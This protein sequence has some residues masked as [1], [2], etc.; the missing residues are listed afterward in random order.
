MSNSVKDFDHTLIKHKYLV[1]STKSGVGKTSFSANL[2]VALSKKGGKVGFMDL[3]YDGT[4]ISRVLGLKGS[5][6]TDND[7][8]SMPQA[9]SDNLK[10]ISIE[11]IMK[12]ID[13]SLAFG[14]DFE[15][16]AI[17][18]CI[19]G[20]NW[21]EVDYLIVDSPPGSGD[22][23]LA[24]AQ[25]IKG[26]KVIFV[27][28]SQNE[29]LIEMEKLINFYSNLKIPIFGTIENMSGFLCSECDKTSGSTLQES[30]IMEIDYLGR[31]PL[32]PH[33]AKCTEA[34]ESYLEK[35]P[36]S[37]IAHGCEIIVKKII[38]DSRPLKRENK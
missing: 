15:M 4:N 34:G 1:T 28:T 21:G 36:D 19:T 13:P 32:D 31:I 16:H 18:Q 6:E 33:L 3:D 24:V 17:R 25:A 26:S 14:E 35:Y 10:V 23:S 29:S 2:A 9:Y 7:N 20:V 12:D 11:S 38:E 5:Y 37:E 30:V 8:R 22:K 27:S